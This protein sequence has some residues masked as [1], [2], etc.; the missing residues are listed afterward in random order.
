M[1]GNSTKGVQFICLI[2]NLNYRCKF[3][4]MRSAFQSLSPAAATVE[5]YYV[6]QFLMLKAK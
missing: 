4:S 6:I 2:L 1:L 5:K 3:P